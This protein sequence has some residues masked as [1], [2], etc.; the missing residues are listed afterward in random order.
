MYVSINF[1]L[2]TH[3]YFLPYLFLFKYSCYHKNKLTPG[4]SAPSKCY[5]PYK[6]PDF[7]V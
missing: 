5:S 2:I 7:F 4:D 1:K 6:L 3:V